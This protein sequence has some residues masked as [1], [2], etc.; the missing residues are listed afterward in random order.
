[1]IGIYGVLAYL[2]TL[3]RHEFGVRLAL[4]ARPGDLLKLVL[5]QGLG[6][7]LVGVAGGLAVAMLLTRILD[8]L[9]FGVSARDP[10]T[11]S[12]VAVLL[13]LAALMACYVPAR[14]AS[15]SDPVGA[16]RSE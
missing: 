14:R 11:F 16:L 13:L 3:R 1:M 4:G 10:M 6:L 12:G 9:L 8:S 5:A 2:V 15:R 7:A